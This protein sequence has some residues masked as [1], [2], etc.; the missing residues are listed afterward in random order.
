[1]DAK[2]YG[3]PRNAGAWSREV[4]WGGVMVAQA[5]APAL[6]SPL[7]D[8]DKH[9]VFARFSFVKNQ[10]QR[11]KTEVSSSAA[12]L[13]YMNSTS[14]SETGTVNFLR[15]G[16]FASAWSFSN[17]AVFYQNRWLLKITVPRQHRIFTTNRMFCHCKSTTWF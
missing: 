6:T 14:L 11:I 15:A 8:S 3:Q 13:F 1:M 7:S 17:P 10:Y 5:G 16:C 2:D 12:D 9:K 4:I